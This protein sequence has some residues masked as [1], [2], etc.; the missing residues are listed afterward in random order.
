MVWFYLSS[1]LFL[2]WSLGAN[3]AANVFGTAV[4]TRML[5]F[6]LAATVAALFVILGAV[7]SGA[8]PA[9]TYSKLGAVN[10]LGGSFTVA[11]AAAL[12]VAWMTRV[13][14]PVSTTQ[15]IVGAIVGWDLFVGLPVDRPTLTK[16]L[17]TWVASPVLTALFALLGVY[18]VRILVYRVRIHLLDLDL[19][20]RLG[21][22]LI[23]AFGA[24][25]LGANNIANVMGVFVGSNPFRDIAAFGVF[26]LT[27]TQVLFLVG[28]LAIAVGILTYSHR[29]IRTVG[30]EILKLSPL[31]AWIV[32]AAE[33]L[34]LFIFASR[35]LQQLLMHLHL[36]TIPLVPVSSSQ[37]VVGGVIGIGLAKGGGRALNLGVLRR[38]VWGWVVTPVTAGLLSF[39]GLFFMQNVFQQQVY[40]PMVYIV[41][42][43][44]LAELH[45]LGIH[46]P[47]LDSLQGKTIV[48]ARP[49]QH[50]LREAGISGEALRRVLQYT[51]VDSLVVDAVLARQALPPDLFPPAYLQPLKALHG[52]LFLHHWQLER[53]LARLSPAWQYR[54]ATLE[55]QAYNRALKARFQLLFDTFRVDRVR[56]FRRRFVLQYPRT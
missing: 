43:E 8:G 17:A 23:A 51:E 6:T 39:F 24:Y 30:N 45:R 3:D 20:T 33:S 53:A 37:A 7:V 11:L 50:L 41:D 22:L 32:V 46:N 21:L 35:S 55:N 5:R 15:A 13:G 2:G 44:A 31:D 52:H 4:A 12:T 16:I 28:G 49:W 38:I 18:L 47:V 34:V 36:P 27:R 9:H 10:A 29:V 48:G 42:E 25:S 1:G 14:L 26:H 54:P 40:R 19:Y 56:A